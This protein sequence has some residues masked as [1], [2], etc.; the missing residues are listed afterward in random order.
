MVAGIK[1]ELQVGA[2]LVVA[3]VAVSWR[4]EE[5]RTRQGRAI[6]IITRE[7][8]PG[9]PG[10]P[11]ETFTIIDRSSRKRLVLPGSYIMSPTL[12]PGVKIR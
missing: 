3:L 7:G 1:E 4:P 10:Y 2:E 9:S 11:F 12:W 5:Q 8:M 6:A